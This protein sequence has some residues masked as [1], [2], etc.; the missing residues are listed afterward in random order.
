MDAPPSSRERL[1]AAA[2]RLF[3]THG[4]NGVSVRD[5]A[6]A[7]EVNSASIGYYFGGKEGLLTEVYRLAAEPISAERRR[8][9]AELDTRGGATLE[10]LLDAFIRPALAA[11]PAGDFLRMRTILSAEN[12]AVFARL[13]AES[14]DASSR[15]FIERLAAVL[16]ALPR[17]ALLWRF[18]FLLGTIYYSATGP[19]R[20][21]ALSDGACDPREVDRLLANLVPFLAAGLRSP[22]PAP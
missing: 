4:Y 21:V 6:S 10:E 20:I 13:T 3:A 12:A 16:P 14:F 9:F 19:Q 5:I 7:A 18:H 22:A 2:R 1:L 11:D 15:A 17:P 8:R